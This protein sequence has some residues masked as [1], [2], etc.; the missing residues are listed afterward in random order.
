MVAARDY[1]VVLAKKRAIHEAEAPSLVP[2][3]PDTMAPVNKEI[4]S[5]S[6]GPGFDAAPPTL[7]QHVLTFLIIM[8]GT[9]DVFRQQ[10]IVTN[11]VIPIVSKSAAPL[12]DDDPIK[13]RAFRKHQTTL[14]K[15]PLA[16][17]RQSIR[18]SSRSQ[19]S[20]QTANSFLFLSDNR[21]KDQLMRTSYSWMR[22]SIKKR[23]PM[24]NK[25]LSP[26]LSTPTPLATTNQ[27]GS[28]SSNL[29]SS[30]A[31]RVRMASLK[32]TAPRASMSPLAGVFATK[33]SKKIIGISLG[34]V[35]TAQ[36]NQIKKDL[37]AL[38]A[39]GM[40]SVTT[41]T[42]SE[43]LAE[44]NDLQKQYISNSEIRKNLPIYEANLS[45]SQEQ[46][47]TC[48]Q[49]MEQVEKELAELAL[50]QQNVE[51][52]LQE[53]KDQISAKNQELDPTV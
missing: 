38:M 6:L 2:N 33:L 27:T 25:S 47:Q 24:G 7:F 15:K 18:L 49:Q 11:V 3:Y 23:K 51:M 35:F 29:L 46:V 39:G 14:P 43:F 20:R 40:T 12:T 42:I 53:I 36:A 50:V 48:A 13:E 22:K 26:L 30:A 10:L 16:A 19:S 8:P 9:H 1:S 17:T 41:E 37:E 21:D 4:R 52:Q 31:L 44:F 28:P 5:Y 34:Q 45:K 32:T